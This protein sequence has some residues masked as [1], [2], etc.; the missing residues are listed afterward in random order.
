MV[1]YTI[2]DYAASLF[3]NY[4]CEL[5]IYRIILCFVASYLFLYLWKRKQWGKVYILSLS[6]YMTLLLSITIL[7]R[8]PGEKNSIDTVLETYMLFINGKRTICYEIVYNI[9]LF[10]PAGMLFAIKYTWEKSFK[11]SISLSVLIEIFQII[12]TVG[13]FE[14]PDIIHNSLGGL[15]GIVLFEAYRKIKLTIRR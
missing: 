5:S 10:V 12:T 14:L 7:G 6:I 11:I 4:L 15:L 3:Q 9:L 13:V 8:R 2:I 1:I